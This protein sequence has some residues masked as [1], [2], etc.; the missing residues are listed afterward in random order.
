MPDRPQQA[1]ADGMNPKLSNPMKILAFKFGA[2]PAVVV[3]L[4]LSHLPLAVAAP[5]EASYEKAVVRVV[6]RMSDGQV[7]TGTGFFINLN[8]HILTNYHVIE[9]ANGGASGDLRIRLE[10]SEVG[11][12]VSVRK[13]FPAYDLAILKLDGIEPETVLSLQQD[14]IEKGDSVYAVGYPG[15]QDQIAGNLRLDSTLTRGVISSLEEQTWTNA[16]NSQLSVIGHDAII[17]RGNSG[18]PLINECSHVVGVNTLQSVAQG[19]GNS[20][21]RALGYASHVSEVM[22]E[23]DIL[24][25]DFGVSQE[26]CDPNGEPKFNILGYANTLAIAALAISLGVVLFKQPRQAVVQGARS[27]IAKLRTSGSV[28]NN[29]SVGS[30]QGSHISRPAPTHQTKQ[31]HPVNHCPPILLDAVALNATQRGISYGQSSAVVDQLLQCDGLSPRHF[32]ISYSSGVFFMEDL[33]S[34]SGTFINKQRLRPYFAQSLEAGDLVE[35][36]SAQWRVSGG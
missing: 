10:G 17:N 2:L 19:A 26:R 27:T 29:A 4:S 3:L 25:I 20:R 15:A 6:N 11:H 18:G 24:G 16:P 1:G 36:G 33:N 22:R 28:A 34:A 23:L 7:A 35:A 8:G 21:I 12:R 31:L 14:F 32:R 9:D 30:M 5:D 13:F